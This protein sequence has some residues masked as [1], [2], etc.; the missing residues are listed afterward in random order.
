MPGNGRVSRAPHLRK[1]R[2]VFPVSQRIKKQV[3]ATTKPIQAVIFDLD[4]TLLDWSARQNPLSDVYRPH[5]DKV[6]DYLRTAGHP[7]PDRETF[8]QSHL[9]VVTAAWAEAKKDWT[10]VNI[11]HTLQTCFRNL[12]LDVAQI[13]MTA[14]LHAYDWQATP[15]VDLYEDTIPVLNDLRCQAYKIGLITNSMLPMWMRDIELRTY[16][17]LDYFDVRLTSGDVGFMKPH[18]AIFQRALALLEVE[19]CRAV[20]VGDRPA[21]DIAGANAAGLIS[22]LMAPPHINHDLKTVTPDFVI[23]RLSELLPLLASLQNGTGG[24]GA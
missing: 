5:A 23:T 7:L 3:S 8:F 19:P 24:S 1:E 22:V 16:G 13:D 18:P 6:Y 12:K 21:N 4:D 2:H 17:I 9:A 14:V 11:A 20:F 10:A 15:H